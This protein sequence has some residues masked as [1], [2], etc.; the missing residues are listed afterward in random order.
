MKSRILGAIALTALSVTAAPSGVP[1]VQD[2]RV[3]GSGSVVRN[4]RGG[5]AHVSVSAWKPAA[6]DSSEGAGTVSV[7]LPGQRMRNGAVECLDVV[8]NRAA[9][10][11][12]LDG[13]GKR[14][15]S[16]G[17]LDTGPGGSKN[18]TVILKFSD[19]GSGCV[20]PADENPILSGNFTVV[21][22]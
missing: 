11:A 2:D 14:Y 21:D 13:P 17:I 19:S 4:P 8:G 16:I 6:G 5:T 15:A 20:V 1:A 7:K 9:V 22:H 3:T 10:V 18:D 12:T